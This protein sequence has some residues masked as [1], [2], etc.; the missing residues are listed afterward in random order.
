VEVTYVDD[1]S[2]DRSLS[3]L[4]AVAARDAR[5]T[6]LEPAQLGHQPAHGGWRSRKATV[7]CSWTEISRIR[8]R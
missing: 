2:R 3:L 7:S 8:R 1:G 6:V 4:R 5:V